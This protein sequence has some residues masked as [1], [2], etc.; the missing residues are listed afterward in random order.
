MAVSQYFKPPGLID[1]VTNYFTPDVVRKASSLVGESESSTRSALSGAVPTL[2]HGM[3]NM[4]SSREGASTFSS[5]IRDGDYGAAAESVGSLFGGG[6]ASSNMMSAGSQLLG[7]FFG[8]NTSSV[9]NVVAQAGGVSSSSA[10]KLLS[11][12]APLTLGVLGK[13]AASQGTGLSGITSELL[14]QKSDIAAAAPSGLSRLFASGPTIVRSDVTDDP[15]LRAPAPSM[16][17]HFADRT[18]YAEPAVKRYTEPVVEERA[19]VPWLPLLLAALLVGLGL[20]LLLRGRGTR[21]PNLS[22]PAV[23]TSSIHLPNGVTLGVP[24]GSINDNLAT[25]LAD[26]SSGNLPQTFTFDHLNFESASTQLTPGSVATVNSLA[27]VLKAYPN[28]RVELVG[29]TDNTGSPDTNQTLS[30]D[31]ANAIKGILVN[32]G[33][34]ADRIATNGYGQTRP[35]ASNDTEDGRARN[36]RI[37][38][39]VL[40][41]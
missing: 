41:K 7:K 3:A 31:R 29:H 13:R 37:E 27:Q 22:V 39:N 14:E 5:L 1:A 8:N 17:E 18:D 6:K 34:D 40:N 12:V 9:A 21:V 19:R 20:W 30:I 35:I 28:A 15:S 11:L 26:R 24:R 2:L 10:T 32:Q 33:V 16:I 23:N 36:R 4:A 38:L 25:F